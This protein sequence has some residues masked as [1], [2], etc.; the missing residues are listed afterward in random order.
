MLRQTVNPSRVDRMGAGVS[1][2]CAIHCALMPFVVTLLPVLGLGF[3]IDPRVERLIILISVA[4]ATMSACWGIRIHRQQRLLVIFGT[5]VVLILV[6][7]T[8]GNGLLEAAMVV[9]GAGLFICGH[10]VNQRLC[11]ACWD[12]NQSREA[13]QAHPET[14]S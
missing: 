1:F 12:C 2:A 13:R 14:P 9:A 7:H 8:L 4:L 6:G 10:V 11:Q 5:A 3:I